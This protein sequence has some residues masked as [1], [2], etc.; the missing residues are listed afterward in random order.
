MLCFSFSL[1]SV[2]CACGLFGV[3]RGFSFRTPTQIYI[4][5]HTY[6]KIN[7]NYVKNKYL[8][9]CKGPA[10]F[11]ICLSLVPNSQLA[12]IGVKC[13]ICVCVCVLAYMC[14]CM[15]IF[16]IRAAK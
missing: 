13:I 4:N 9:V 11:T 5:I 6:G 3:S 12:C 15:R 14:V 7:E 10:V 8:Y 16:V 1:L 2:F